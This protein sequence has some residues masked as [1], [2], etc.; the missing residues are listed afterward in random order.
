MKVLFLTKAYAFIPVIFLSIIINIAHAGTS[1]TSN[2]NAL[3]IEARTINTQVTDITLTTDNLCH[4]L[5]S[6]HQAARALINN[7]ETVNASLA[8]PIT[9]D[10][11]SMQA[12]DD[13]SAVIVSLAASSTTLSSDL[14]ALNST[15]SMLV[16]SNGISAMLRL[17]DDIGI[18]AD[19]IL[20]MA[21]KILIMADNIGVMADRIILTQKIQ[22]D[23]LALTQAS[24]LTTQANSLAL[25]SV[26]NSSSYN[27][28]FKT[29]TLNGNNLAT[30]IKTTVLTSFNMASKWA[31]LSTDVTGLLAQ[32]NTTHAAIITALSSN[33]VYVDADSYKSLADM[34]IMVSS[35][36]I[37]IQ[38]LTLATEGLAPITR[39]STLSN[40]MGSILQISSDI[41]IMADRI[42]EMAD[43]ILAMADNIGLA[44][45]QIITTQQLQNTNYATTLGSIET[46][47]EIAIS[48]IA[49]NSL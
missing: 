12:L 15:G 4:E 38:G 26:I 11:D 9:V 40:S 7:I 35:L 43:L 32:I 13:L 41:G 45:D 14:A 49:I 30:V 3:L 21:D 17:A 29:Q 47:Q 19:R 10:N 6:A 36:S 22:S 20:E 27:A 16:I 31:S 28:D 23:N 18:M 46:T 25:V 44:A 5:L 8:G 33:T 37:A 2:L 1:P 42:L 24:V 48:I 34:N 39:D